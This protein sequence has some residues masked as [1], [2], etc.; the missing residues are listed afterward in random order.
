[1]P[2]ISTTAPVLTAIA[3]LTGAAVGTAPTLVVILIVLAPVAAATLVLT[4][5]GLR[6]TN[7]GPAA[8]M[9]LTLVELVLLWRR[10]R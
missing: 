4:W 6:G 10:R 5:H 3:S 8:S 1:M 7:P 9:L 2:D